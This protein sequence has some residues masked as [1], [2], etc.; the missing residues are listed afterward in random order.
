MGEEVQQSYQG[1]IKRVARVWIFKKQ[2]LDTPSKNI[3]DPQPIEDIKRIYLDV[4]SKISERVTTTLEDN[5]IPD[6]DSSEDIT[7]REKVLS[8]PKDT[9]EGNHYKVIPDE[10]S[11]MILAEVAKVLVAWVD[12]YFLEMGPFLLDN[13]TDKYFDRRMGLSHLLV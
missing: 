5:L 13:R 11:A 12:C 4:C 7:P 3:N 1:M 2:S 9:G 8:V 10:A 6:E